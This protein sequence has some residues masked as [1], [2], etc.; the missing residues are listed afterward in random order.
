LR[1]GKSVTGPSWLADSLAA[2][3][4]ATALYC[5]GHLIA[6]WVHGRDAEPDVDLIHVAMGVAMAGVLVAAFDQRANLGWGL[7]F[8]VCAGWFA[9]RGL[10]AVL[11]RQVRSRGLHHLQHALACAAMV[12]MFAGASVPAAA[13]SGAMPAMHHGV[14]G[15]AAQPS[16]AALG[17]TVVLLCHAGWNVAELVATQRRSTRLGG[18]AAML[19]PRLAIGCSIAMSMTMSYMLLR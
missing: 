14:N 8:A 17:L 6:S 19:A 12:Y 15:I 9:L 13:A 10:R 16:L 2:L 4:L 7:V 3:M 1:E 18:N 11:R 5:I